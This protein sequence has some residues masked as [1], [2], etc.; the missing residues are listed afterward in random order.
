MSTQLTIENFKILEELFG[1]RDFRDN[2][3]PGPLYTQWLEEKNVEE[4]TKYLIRSYQ[5]L[6]Y[7]DINRYLR[8]DTYSHS[9]LNSHFS[10]LLNEALDILP[11][12]SNSVVWRKEGDVEEMLHWGT[13]HQGQ[14][15]LIPSFWSTYIEAMNWRSTSPTFKILTSANSNARSI[16]EYTGWQRGETEALYK[17]NTLFKILGVEEVVTWGET[18]EK[19]IVLE[20]TQ[21]V[22]ATI[23]ASEGYHISQDDADHEIHIPSLN[24]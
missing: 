3:A 24:D 1:D 19:V 21:G 6:C 17:K 20:E 18:V 13:E 15:I 8:R 10:M 7:Q 4:L 12:L 22:E 23:I 2:C 14:I 11:P 9:P 5:Q 16:A